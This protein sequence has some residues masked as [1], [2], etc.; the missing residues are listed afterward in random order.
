MPRSA[1]IAFMA[2]PAHGHVNPGLGLVAELAA[3]GHRVTY[4]VTEDFAPQ[5]AEAGAEPV[6]Y[7]STLPSAA[8]QQEWPE[9]QAAAVLLFVDEMISVHPQLGAAYA[10]DRP[11]LVIYDIGTLQAPVLAHEWGVPA[12]CLSPTHVRFEG[13]EEVFGFD[14]SPELLAVHAKA[15]AFFA[16]HGAPLTFATMDREC[17]VVTIPRSFQYYAESVAAN[18]TFVGPMLTARRTQGTWQRSGAR[19]VLL[20]SMGSAF[21]DQP[22]LYRDCLAAFGGLDWQVVLS[23]GEVV[24]PAVLG[25]VPPNVEVH[26]WVPQLD[27][28][29]QADAFITHAGMGGTMEALHAGVPMIAIP[30]AAEQFANAARIAELGL[31]VHLPKEEATPQALRAAL[32]RVSTDPEVLARSAAMRREI[33]EAGGARRAAEIVEARLGAESA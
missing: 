30:Q 16:E 33:G 26:R 31:G 2:V 28:L 21:T 5:V 9:D 25:E 22:Q 24:D 10:A 6:R 1:H 14:D 7:T 23:I 18:H 13:I 27:V 20:I 3:R 29:S 15:D 17:S 8:T 11:D 19:P 32:H 12:I 4:A